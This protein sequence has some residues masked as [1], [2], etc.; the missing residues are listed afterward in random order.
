[1]ADAP[2]ATYRLQ[3]HADFPFDAALAQLDYFSELGISHL[4]C[5]PI[6]Q[7]AHGSRHGYDVV[8]PTRISDELGGEAAFRT[9]AAAAHERGMGILIDI[10]PNHMCTDDAASVWWRDVLE[11]GRWS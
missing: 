2:R 1:M 4:Y 11:D 9:L 8:D 7:A 3:L 5:S 10:V 6:T